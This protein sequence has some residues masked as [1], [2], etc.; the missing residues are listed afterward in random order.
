MGGDGTYNEV[1][2]G[3]PAGVPLGLLPAARRPC[4]PGSWG[5]PKNVLRT[6]EGL[7]E[8]IPAGSRARAGWEA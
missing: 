5:W 1:V 2:N 6:A 3:L 4:S 7:A 8:S